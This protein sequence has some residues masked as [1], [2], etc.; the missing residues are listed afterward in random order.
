VYIRFIISQC[1]V[2]NFVDFISCYS[3]LSILYKSCIAHILSL[4][5]IAF[6]VMML[7]D[8]R[9]LIWEGF[10]LAIDNIR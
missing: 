2:I 1:C 6:C 5:S 8:W 7:A 3:L 4:C 9:I 10:L